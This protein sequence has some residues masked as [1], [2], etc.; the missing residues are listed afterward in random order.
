[1]VEGVAQRRR[2]NFEVSEAC[3][4]RIIFF[5]RGLKSCNHR[6]SA[7]ENGQLIRIAL[8]ETFS[9][10][11]QPFLWANKC[12]IYLMFQTIRDRV[13]SLERLY[14]YFS[15]HNFVLAYWRCHVSVCTPTGVQ[16][17][18][19][20]HYYSSL[21]GKEDISSI[22]KGVALLTRSRVNYVS[23]DSI[24]RNELVI[25]IIIHHF[26]VRKTYQVL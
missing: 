20:Y 1:M 17:Q 10:T 11:G 15:V 16:F 26:L 8:S 7:E 6:L 24:P 22:K 21:C 12:R 19:L 25:N 2:V 13:E 14:G 3:L 4:P 23:G 5:F 9:L 18:C